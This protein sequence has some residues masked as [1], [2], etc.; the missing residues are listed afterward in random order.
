MSNIDKVKES[1]EESKKK[2]KE[3]KKELKEKVSDL[4][5]ESSKSLFAEYSDLESFSWRQ[6]TVYFNDGDTCNFSARTESLWI[7]GCRTETYG[8]TVDKVY[9]EDDLPEN[10]SEDR[11]K[12]IAIVV[13]NFLGC[14][15]DDDLEEMFGDHAEVS[16][17]KNGVTI[18]EYTDHD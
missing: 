17:S 16:V 18:S 13:Y 5:H 3:I 6:Y 4:F 9:L 2:I 1:I 12:A 7:N 10:I 14:F 11:F 8:S 15:D